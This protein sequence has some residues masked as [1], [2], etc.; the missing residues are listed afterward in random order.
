[1]LYNLFFLC[2]F[3]F[4]L[5]KTKLM[6]TFKTINEK[7]WAK[8]FDVETLAKVAVTVQKET[9]EMSWVLVNPELIDVEVPECVCTFEFA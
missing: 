9:D 5:L 1:M 8:V 6:E 7:E 2:T 4:A 3:A